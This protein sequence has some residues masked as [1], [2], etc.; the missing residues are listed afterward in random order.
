MYKQT[1]LGLTAAVLCLAAMIVGCVGIGFISKYH[2]FDGKI[3]ILI[4][5]VHFILIQVHLF[6]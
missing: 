4:L 2:M 5:Y 1:V 6:Y 3:L